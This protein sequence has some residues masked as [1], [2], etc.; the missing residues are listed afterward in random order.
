MNIATTKFFACLELQELLNVSNTYTMH[1]F[2]HC[3]DVLQY[4]QIYELAFMQITERC[5][6]N[7][8]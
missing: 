7:S 4:K 2:S 3:V 6:I 1:L 8:T 5:E